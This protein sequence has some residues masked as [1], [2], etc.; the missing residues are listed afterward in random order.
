MK[1]DW[2][3]K[4]Q[5]MEEIRSGIEKAQQAQ[6]QALKKIAPEYLEQVKKVMEASSHLP[7]ETQKFLAN[8]AKM[9]E[10]AAKASTQSSSLGQ[11][12]AGRR[13]TFSDAKGVGSVKRTDESVQPRPNQSSDIPS[14]NLDALKQWTEDA[15][16]MALLD[17]IHTVM[18]S[19]LSSSDAQ[20]DEIM[21]NEKTVRHQGFAI[22]ALTVAG[23]AFGAWESLSNDD[24]SASVEELS[25]Q[26]S[27]LSGKLG[28][29]A[30][31]QN[32]ELR[33][34]GVDDKTSKEISGAPSE[35]PSGPLPV[36]ATEVD[37]TSATH[38][39]EPSNNGS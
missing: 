24:F 30:A 37:T 23:L 8:Y 7:P 11:P 12:P 33:K 31:V 26:V 2:I 36:P 14:D 16:V 9:S 35:K 18:E 20:H 5:A 13:R 3:A 29:F 17:K 19:Q 25:A 32:F 34:S 6:A 38:K 22:L 21:R 10:M 4:K 28:E 15:E 1:K 27:S 39:S